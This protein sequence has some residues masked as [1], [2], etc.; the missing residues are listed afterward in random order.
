MTV[1]LPS[2]SW[3]SAASPVSSQIALVDPQSHAALDRMTGYA[4]AAS[5]QRSKALAHYWAEL[6]VSSTSLESFK[7][8][9]QN[10]PVVI[11][12]DAYNVTMASAGKQGGDGSFPPAI[13]CEGG[14]E[15]DECRSSTRSR[16]TSLVSPPSVLLLHPM[17]PVL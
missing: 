5:T 2:V 8:A 12:F 14:L 15:W 1:F 16:R 13:S 3:I 17:L 10:A 6:N 4:S 9:L 11:P 7:L